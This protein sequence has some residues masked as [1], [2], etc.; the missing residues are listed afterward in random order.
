MSFPKPESN[1][2]IF[3]FLTNIRFSVESISFGTALKD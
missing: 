2:K 3:F 1:T